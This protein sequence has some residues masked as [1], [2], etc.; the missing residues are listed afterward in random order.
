PN[1]D[2]L[3][4]VREAGKVTKTVSYAEFEDYYEGLSTEIP[5][6]EEYINN[7]RATWNI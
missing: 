2:F 6:D 3:T 1:P 4:F 7:L 5:D